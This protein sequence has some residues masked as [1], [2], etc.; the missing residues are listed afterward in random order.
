MISA[1]MFAVGATLHVLGQTGG[2]A[3]TVEGHGSISV[4]TLSQAH[5][6]WLPRLM[7]GPVADAAD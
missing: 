2:D 5:E 6:G 7:A 1:L 4:K 3:L